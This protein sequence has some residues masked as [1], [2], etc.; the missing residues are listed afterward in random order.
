MKIIDW[1][2]SY[3][4]DPDPKLAYLKSMVGGYSF[5]AI[6]QEV[7]PSQRDVLKDKF[8]NFRYS[9]D[10]REP[11][12]FDTRQ[13]K[14]G[15]AIICSDDIKIKSADVLNR[16]LLPD[17][18]LM[19]NV[20]YKESMLR[21]MGMHSITGIAHKQAKSIQFLS[22]AEAIDEYKPDI[23]AFDANE[24]AKD[25][26]DI[27]Q[28]EFFSQYLRE[29]GYGAKT[30]FKTLK[31]TGL[32]DAFT[33][34]YDIGNYI[35]GEPLAV[36]HHIK[37][38]DHDRRYDFVFIKSD[39]EVK[40]CEYK[41]DEAI[42]AGSDHALICTDLNIFDVEET[43]YYYIKDL[44]LFAKGTGISNYYILKNGKWVED[45]K[46]LVSDRLIGYDPYEDVPEYGI[47]NTEIMR[48][49]EKIT[50]EEYERGVNDVK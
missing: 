38:T 21:V 11:G 32:N 35:E 39:M 9:L 42:K 19:V 8:K 27:E 31:D 25:H 40:D 10:Y 45:K 13:R 20:E 29:N 15:I 2:I 18:T 16:S 50:K 48:T 44:N 7:T 30:F 23:V 26:Y 37:R 49:I 46:H 14:L 33:V 5:I 41:Y 3:D 6:L 24:P 17:R 34:N 43:Q 28:M 1:N 4:N 12:K 22:W 36:S 47:G